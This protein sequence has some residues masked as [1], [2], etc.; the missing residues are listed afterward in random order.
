MGFVSDFF[1]G[2]PDAPDPMKSA[3]AQM[4]LN[5][6][7]ALLNASLNRVGQVTPYGSLSYSQ[8]GTDAQGN[9]SFTATQTLTP[10]QQAIL[11]ALEGNQQALG[12]TLSSLVGNTT[13][14]Y[15]NPLSLPD[16]PDFSTGA[17][18]VVSQA[19]DRQLNYLNPYFN[20]QFE[21]LDAQMRNQGLVPGMPAYDRAL[22]TLQQTQSES[23]GQF[24][25]QFQ[26]LAFSQQ[27]QQHQ[28]A[29]DKALQEYQSPLNA[30][31]A[32]FGLT[33]PGSPSFVTPSPVTAA[34]PD[35]MKAI[36]DQYNAEMEQ[37][38]LG[39]GTL[40][41]IGSKIAGLPVGTATPVTLGGKVGQGLT[42]LLGL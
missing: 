13:D 36:Q 5:R 12:G 41:G 7:T 8:T 39:W 11:D 14:L 35:I 24:L 37:Y 21:N 25:N 4:G 23:V 1:S 28:A 20:Q 22:R 30:M 2:P 34:S 19:M 29:R 32:L 31:Q 9:P 16:I 27:L 10:D 38:Q 3:E 17:S 42:G 15:G 26:P 6:N 33:K 18:S 40:M